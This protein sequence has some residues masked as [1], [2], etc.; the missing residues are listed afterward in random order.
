MRVDRESFM[1]TKNVTSPRPAGRPADRQNHIIESMRDQILRGQIAPGGRLPTREEMARSFGAGTHTVQRALDKLKSDGFIESNERGTRVSLQPPH[2][3]RY[4]VVFPGLPD[5][6]SSWVRFWTVLSD[7]VRKLQAVPGNDLV[8]YYDVCGDQNTP[9]YQAL[10]ADVLSHSIAGI[11]F[12]TYPHRLVG[13]PVL[14]ERGI[15]RVGIMSR[16]M[17][18]TIPSISLDMASFQ[19]K[20]VA[21]LQRS[22]CRRIASLNAPGL[23]VGTDLSRFSDGKTP[24]VNH[25]YWNL[26]GHL[27]HPETSYGLMQLLFQGPRENRPDGLII[28]DD[29]FVE[30]AVQGVLAAGVD[31]PKDLR[32]VAHSN[33]P[34]SP[35]AA[36]PVTFLGF[37]TREIL[38]LA[39]GCINALRQGQPSPPGIELEPRFE[40]E[41]VMECGR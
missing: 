31:V 19:R 36:A 18:P 7:E 26:P 25:P 35:P 9:D 33:F 23:E 2:L 24:L 15:P 32:I 28:S 41:L 6:G 39:I 14:E 30:H 20:A 37:D 22:G 1:A 13:T 8:L 4:A 17:R 3:N 21:E 38:H 10:L 11:I 34:S 16:T 29:N 12:V 27:L 40:T 5:D